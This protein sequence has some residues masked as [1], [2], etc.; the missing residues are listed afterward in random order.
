MK[1]LWR[2]VAV[3]VCCP[4][5]AASRP[6]QGCLLISY[7]SDSRLP[8]VFSKSLPIR[9]TLSLPPFASSALVGLVSVSQ[10]M[11]A[12][13]CFFFP[14]NYTK[15]FKLIMRKQYLTS[16]HSGGCYNLLGSHLLI[17]LINVSQAT[18]TCCENSEKLAADLFFCFFEPNNKVFLSIK[19]PVVLLHTAFTKTPKQLFTSLFI[20]QSGKLL[21]NKMVIMI[22]RPCVMQNSLL[23]MF[24][25][26]NKWA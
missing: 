20:Q 24:S 25:A 11:K 16:S 6:M 14:P 17:F 1:K 19:A 26:K 23:L 13:H 21:Q 7:W 3:A 10:L 22:Q 9:Q 4:P 8:I 2:S 5:P 12:L 18:F 15:K